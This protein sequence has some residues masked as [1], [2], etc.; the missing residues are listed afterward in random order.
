METNWNSKILKSPRWI[1]AGACALLLS[2]C[3]AQPY[4][5]QNTSNV[6]QSFSLPESQNAPLPGETTTTTSTPGTSVNSNLLPTIIKRVEGVGYDQTVS[7][8]VRVRRILKVKFT[9]GIADKTE[10]GTGFTRHYSGLGVYLSV[11]SNSQPTPLLQNAFNGAT[12]ESKTI[13]FSGSFTRSCATTD[14]SCRQFVTITVS[15]PNYDYLCLVERMCAPY[16][17]AWTHV[18]ATHPWNGT[19]EIQTDDT[20]G[21]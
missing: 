2:A 15:K 16:F 21:L 7:V 11:E 6:A 10:A 17:P 14:T 13:D 5:S 4:S 20:S 8:E 12:P 9:P 18:A 19:L 1:A 3:G